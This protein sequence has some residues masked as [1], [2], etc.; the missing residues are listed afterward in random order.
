VKKLRKHVG[1]QMGQQK[2]CK[3]HAGTARDDGR[4]WVPFTFSSPV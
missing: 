2:N 1:Q 3:T 4:E